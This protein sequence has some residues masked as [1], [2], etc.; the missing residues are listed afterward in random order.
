M[1]IFP[2]LNQKRNKSH[3]RIS[4]IFHNRSRNRTILILRFTWILTLFYAEWFQFYNQISSCQW[5]SIPSDEAQPDLIPNQFNLLI[6]AD[7]QLPSIPYSY[8]TRPYLLQAISIQI[9][10]QFIRKSWRLL[11]R[12]RK[13]DAIIF[14]G[15]LLDGGVA[16]VDQSEYEAY[17]R[18]FRHTFPIPDSLTESDRVIHLAGNH[19]LGLAPWTNSSNSNLARERFT[20]NF[21]PGKLSGHTEWGN[22]S[23][24]WIDAIGLIEEEKLRRQNGDEKVESPVKGFIEKLNGPDTLL[25]K[26]LFTHVP[27]WRPEGTSCGPLR[28]SRREIHQGSGKNYQNEITE[29][30]SKSVLEK[31]QPTIV[32]SGDDHDY[33][34]VIHTIPST[35][36]ANPSPSSIH[37]ISVKSFSMGMGI[38]RP[39]YQ[40][41]SL[42]NPSRFDKLPEKDTTFDTSCILPNQIKTYTHLYVPL[43]LV[44]LIMIFGI[45]IWNLFK[46][47]RSGIRQQAKTNGLPIHHRHRKSISRTLM[48]TKKPITAGSDSS[49]EE[50]RSDEESGHHRLISQHSRQ[51]ASLSLADAHQ[52]VSILEGNHNGF[53]SP[54]SA[55]SYHSPV[56]SGHEDDRI[57]HPLPN[58]QNYPSGAI[59]DQHESGRRTSNK[60]PTLPSRYSNLSNSDYY[61]FQQHTRKPPLGFFFRILSIFVGKKR[62]ERWKR[63]SGVTKVRS[64][65]AK[66]RKSE[67]RKAFDEFWKV[68]WVI[69]L[70][71]GL[72]WFWFW[73]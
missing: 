35:S 40:L 29:E 63:R 58:Y 32:F 60:R 21:Q 73:W 52:S 44:T 66:D 70:V 7:P 71:Y 47:N 42:S 5:P 18:T 51:S 54:T 6:I 33:C 22:H 48:F 3:R 41:L 61:H 34:D 8:P 20:Q 69:G 13:P 65:S 67:I 68:I 53:N 62:I 1:T 36:Y 2:L 46:C 50:N 25:P 19:D 43:F 17:L 64:K 23:I 39:G 15:D 26:V 11:I 16:T 38:Q 57:S 37:E 10:N 30:L 27:L 55:M 4:S 49:S 31:I 59:V 12:I 72:I 14:L 9:I 56:D 28:E 45:P 24:I